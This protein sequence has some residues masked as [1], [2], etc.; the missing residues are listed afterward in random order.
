MSAGIRFG[1]PLGRPEHIPYPNSARR[2][3]VVRA[4]V[5]L[6]H[7]VTEADAKRKALVVGAGA[8]VVRR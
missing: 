4:G 7:H 2:W 8:E 3:S 5:V 1:R 6:S